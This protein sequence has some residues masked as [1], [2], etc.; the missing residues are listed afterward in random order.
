MSEQFHKQMDKLYYAFMFINMYGIVL[1]FFIRPECNDGWVAVCLRSL[2]ALS[3]PAVSTN[4][5]SVPR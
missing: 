1:N 2:I 4:H 5:S 3:L